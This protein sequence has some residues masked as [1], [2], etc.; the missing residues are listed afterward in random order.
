M[1]DYM[2]VCFLH[3]VNWGRFGY[4]I[5]ISYSIVMAAIDAGTRRQRGLFGL[6]CGTISIK[7]SILVSP[8]IH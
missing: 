3:Q 2:L 6:L 4:T 7:K 5:V 8:D 1:D